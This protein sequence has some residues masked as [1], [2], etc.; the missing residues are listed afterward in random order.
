MPSFDLY[1]EHSVIHREEQRK[2][3]QW[4][5]KSLTRWDLDC[6]YPAPG[7]TSI[8]Q[9]SYSVTA[10]DIMMSDVPEQGWAFLCTRGNP[11]SG[12]LHMVWPWLTRCQTAHEYSSKLLPLKQ[13]QDSPL[14]LHP[15]WTSG[16]PW[17]IIDW[18]HLS[19]NSFQFAWR[20]CSKSSFV[21]SFLG[22]KP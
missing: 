19:T 14:L 20:D 9:L 17:I 2:I 21:V 3:D 1:F 5:S 12:A 18:E 4:R 6:N 15:N 8:G 13:Q 7:E 11:G 10:V 22:G 16:Y